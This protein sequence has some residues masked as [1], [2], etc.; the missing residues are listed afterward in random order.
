MPAAPFARAT[1]SRTAY[2]MTLV[3]A[4]KVTVRD[5]LS[6]SLDQE[7]G[8]RSREPWRRL[9]PTDCY[10]V[11]ARTSSGVTSR[12]NSWVDV[13]KSIA[14]YNFATCSCREGSWRRFSYTPA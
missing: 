12:A 6:G 14:A 4:A 3:I 1:G 9:A 13:L 10:A 5:L 11:N 8:P 7:C 2:A